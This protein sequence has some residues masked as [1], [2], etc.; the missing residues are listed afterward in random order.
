MPYCTQDALK[1]IG[2]QWTVEQVMA[3]V[4][5]DVDFYNNSGGGITLSGGEPM[6]QFNFA[7][8]ILQASRERGIHTCMETSGFAPQRKYREILPYVDL[9]LLDYKVTDLD[10]H[11]NLVGV[12][13]KLILSNLDF[14]YTQGVDIILRCPLIPG[15]NDHSGHLEEIAKISLDYPNLKGIEVMAYHDL[16]KD[17]GLRLGQAYPLENIETASNV[18]KQGWLES[19]VALGCDQAAIG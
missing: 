6:G 15:V 9:F 10:A 16:G 8:A 12:S 2:E 3:L 17:K 1:M 7:L 14:I 19:L 4:E 18:I 11:Q 13:N 5:R